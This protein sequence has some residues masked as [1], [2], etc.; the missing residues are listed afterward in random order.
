MNVVEGLC[1]IDLAQLQRRAKRLIER[2]VEL[3]Y[4][5]ES[6]SN[7]WSN[8]PRTK[9]GFGRLRIDSDNSAS[10]P[11]ASLAENIHNGV[12]HLKAATERIN[13]SEHR[14]LS[15]WGQLFLAPNLIE[16]RDTKAGISVA[17]DYLDAF[18]IISSGLQ[19][20]FLNRAENRR[21]DTYLYIGQ[22]RYVRSIMEAAG[23]EP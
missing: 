4:P 3:P 16:E 11:L 12:N 14:D 17:Q 15:I 19:F 23:I 9:P 13:L 8:V 6:L 18:L 20:T 22:R 7:S 1:S 10:L 5:L 21:L 2:F